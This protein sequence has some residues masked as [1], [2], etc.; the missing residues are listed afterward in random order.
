[1][2]AVIVCLG[3]EIVGDDGIGI[4]VGRVLKSAGL[5]EGV[6]V[7]LRPNL[8]WELIELLEECDRMVLV[9]AMTSG[10]EAGSCRVLG[11]DG[12]AQIAA[13]PSC[14]HAIGIP[15]VLQLAAAMHP[16]RPRPEV[17]IVGIEAA[18][19]DEFGIG[20][21]EP[22]RKALPVAVAEV[23]KLL[24]ASAQLRDAAV[25]AAAVEASALRSLTDV[26]QTPES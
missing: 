14:V 2:K 13:C 5:P 1:L 16:T 4:R 11:T 21:S 18:S 20:L 19:M 3:N 22:V 6:R 23:C 12:A 24:G 25:R 26:L 15:E 9:D 7:L 10:R 17:T 8:G